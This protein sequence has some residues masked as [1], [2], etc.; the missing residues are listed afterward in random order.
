MDIIPE[1]IEQVINLLFQVY[2]IELLVDGAAGLFQE[3]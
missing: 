1:L 2:E 3:S